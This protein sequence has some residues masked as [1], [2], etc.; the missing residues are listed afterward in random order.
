MTDIRMKK[1]KFKSLRDLVLFIK[2]IYEC[3]LLINSR[4]YIK[5]LI[6]YNTHL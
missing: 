3:N 5:E 4:V 2:D 6:K 1:L